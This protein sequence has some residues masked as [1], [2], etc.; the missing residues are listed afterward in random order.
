MAEKII[1]PG[2]F[3]KEIDASF[4]PAAVG[5]I[6]AVVVGP[7][8][9]GPALVPTVVNSYSE[10]QAKF[11]DVFRTGSNYY[12]YLTSHTVKNY[13][14][15]SGK[16]TVVRI[17]G[18]GFSP[19]TASILTAGADTST[20]ASNSIQLN[21]E[22]PSGSA[23]KLTINN[24]DF[25][26]V[27]SSSFY[28]DT[29]TDVYVNIGPMAGNDPDEALGLNLANAIGI[30][31]SLT[32]VSASYDATTNRIN[33][34]GSYPG[35]AGHVT[36][37]TSSLAGYEQEPFILTNAAD[38]SVTV[39]KGGTDDNDQGEI[40]F[41]LHTLSDGEVLNS[42]STTIGTNEVLSEGTDNNLRWE[43][44]NRNTK[45]GTFT[46]L[47]R[48]GNDSIKQK[49]ILETWNNLSLD[50]NA[51]NYI[52]KMIGDQKIEIDNS[53]ITDPFLKYT[54]DYT[55]K[56]KYVRVEVVKQTLDYLDENGNIREGNTA[57]A[58]LPAVGSG[59]EGGTFSD[60]SDGKKGDI[61]N[62]MNENIGANTQGIDLNESDQIDQYTSAL[63][64]LSNSDEY[65]FNL[66]LLPGII[67]N[68]TGHTGIITKAVDVCESRGDAFTIVDTVDYGTNGLASVTDQAK[69]LNSNYAATYWPWVQSPD[70]QLGGNVW[71]PPSVVMAGVY[72]FN[73]KVAA[74]WN[75]PAGLNRGVI[76]TAVQA[77]R[78]L[79]HSNRDTL[80]EKNVNPIA[81]FP[82]QGVCVWG[83]KTLQ[84]KA[85]A[86]DRVNVRR[87]LIKVKKFIAASSRFLVFE[88]NNSQT[89]E[90]FLN[91]ANPYLE[92]VQAQS[93]LNAF[94][95]VMDSTNNTPDVVDRNILYGQVFLQPTKTAEFIV[96]DFTIQPTGATFPE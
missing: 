63:N 87:L 79:T 96:L 26:L 35:T 52:S 21:A 84:K 60:C 14:E 90:R 48:K 12:Q 64:L 39:L 47:I 70:L 28:E 4:L 58:S 37:S 29:T 94:K 34:S 2:V 83:Q 18:S 69:A 56:S 33:L 95:V 53:D 51:N 22:T 41:K 30:S 62:S 72:A 91:I 27:Q 19:A 17:A 31:S 13:L 20:F 25:H 8:V 3:T 43:I 11:G 74:P 71:V 81:T 76:S 75:A 77:K 61:F 9:K 68:Q 92:H 55:N 44:A 93:G 40:S 50:P 82:G 6:G 85:S 46:L 73:D 1:S 38:E 42:K 54:G 78:K 32:L 7:T 5:D 66:L 86:L 45:K 16:L 10:F 65:D 36:V 57:T 67:R 15:H 80:Y 89:R 49:Q 24:I 59:S 88:Q 23:Y